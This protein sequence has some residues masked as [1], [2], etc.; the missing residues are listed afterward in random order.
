VSNS[1]L[2]IS[3][4]TREALRLFKN[5]NA[6]LQNIDRQYESEFGNHGAKIGSQLRI[7][8][9][10]DFTVRS[11]AAASPQ[12]TTE[13]QTTLTV[14]T[15]KGVDVQFSS[16]ERALS[17]DDFSKRILAPQ[18][19][20]LAGAVAADIISGSEAIPNVVGKFDSSG[21]LQTPDASTWLQA[22]AQ[23]DLMS[24]PRG[25]RKIIMD[26]MTQAR[27]VS[28]LA[29]LF[30][31]SAGLS[32]QYASGEMYRALG[33]D[34]MADQTVIKHTTGAYGTLATVSGANQT[35]SSVTVSALNGPLKKGDVITFA[36][37]NSVNRVTK[38]DNGVLAQFT[39]TADCATSATSI[40]IY[41]AITPGNVPYA[42]C[43]ASPPNSGA[44]TVVTKASTV[45]RKNFAFLPEA[46]TMV[47]ADLE[48]PKGV[49]EAHRE[50]QDGVSMRMVTGYNV[51][52]DQFITR[53]D[54]LYGYL[55]VRPEWACVVPDII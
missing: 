48:L 46:A 47:T 55:W 2:T 24:A 22:G 42:T 44:I 1:L 3:Q 11:G 6:F 43:T 17:L 12:D 39:V 25:N 21:N 26:P 14:A 49:H 27:T 54:I 37:C 29:G 20:N 28:S 31:P 33:F 36:G 16:A 23:L 52:T 51:S 40:P 5:S 13:Q 35:G 9:P 18:V 8:L 50:Q 30:N 7:R 38:A 32:K 45:Y 10:N 34:W 15:Q 41:P 19:N 4:I 53:L